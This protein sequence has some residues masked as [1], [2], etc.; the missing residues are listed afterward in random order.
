MKGVRV[1]LA[2][3]AGLSG[4]GGPRRHRVQAELGP[5]GRE[6][7]AHLGGRL[8]VEVAGGVPPGPVGA[9]VVGLGE[10]RRFAVGGRFQ[11]ALLDAELDGRGRLGQVL[12]AHPVLDGDGVGGPVV[13]LRGLELL[14]D[15]VVVGLLLPVDDHRVAVDVDDL[16]HAPLPRL[17]FAGAAT[18]G[19]EG[20]GVAGFFGVVAVDRRGGDGVGVGVAAAGLVEAVVVRRAVRGGDHPVLTVVVTVGGAGFQLDAGAVVVLR[21][22]GVGLADPD[23]FGGPAVQRH[24]RV[25]RDPAEVRRPALFGGVVGRALGELLGVVLAGA[26]APLDMARLVLP[27]LTDPRRLR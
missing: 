11:A 14:V 18:G 19:G 4:A 20:V 10:V 5:E 1:H 23:Q 26:V 22:V 17:L 13:L 2:Q 24:H 7:G 8:A 3:R 25:V 12:G 9:R 16:V 27:P 21:T 15:R 6:G